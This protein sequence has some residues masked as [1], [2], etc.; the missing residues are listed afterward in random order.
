MVRARLKQQ[1]WPLAPLWFL[2]LLII[3]SR[4]PWFSVMLGLCAFGCSLSNALL[5]VYRPP[6]KRDAFKTRARGSA[7]KSFIEMG[8]TAAWMLLCALLTWIG[9]LIQR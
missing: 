8:L 5:Q 1:L 6:G 7:V 3:G 2:P 4:Q 9:L